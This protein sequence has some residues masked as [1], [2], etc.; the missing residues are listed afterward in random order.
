[1]NEMEKV[2]CLKVEYEKASEPEEVRGKYED[3]KEYRNNGYYIKEDRN[4]YYLLI[5]PAQLN[6][7]IRD[8]SCCTTHNMKEIVRKYYGRKCISK[9]LADK[10][11]KDIKDKKINILI[12]SQ[13][14]YS[15][16][17]NDNRIIKVSRV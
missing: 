3:T 17:K 16:E 1:M 6:V 12:N 10:F 13:G 7:T 14:D 2:E 4:G 5:K 11:E 15:L 9:K 8:S